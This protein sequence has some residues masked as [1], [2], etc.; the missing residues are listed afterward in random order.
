MGKKHTE[1]IIATVILIIGIFIKANSHSHNKLSRN[2][3]DR[4]IWGFKESGAK[5]TML[6]MEEKVEGESRDFYNGNNKNELNKLISYSTRYYYRPLISYQYNINGKKYTGNRI[7]NYPNIFIKDKYEV[8]N[9]LRNYEIGK[10]V[11]LYYKLDNPKVSYL[12][13]EE[14]YCNIIPIIV[15]ILSLSISIYLFYRNAK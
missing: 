5:I 2:M 14:E 8:M 4:T 9:I 15:T 6:N 13:A 7:S 3:Q 10:H 11:D 1:F 12:I